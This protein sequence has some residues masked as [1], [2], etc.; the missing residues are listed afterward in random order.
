MASDKTS[1]VFVTAIPLFFAA[2]KS[3]FPNPTAKLEIIFTEFGN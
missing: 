1:G 3:I 2:S